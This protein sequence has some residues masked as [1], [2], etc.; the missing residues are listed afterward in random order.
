MPNS[1][2]ES[3]QIPIAGGIGEVGGLS[4]SDSALL[5]ET[6]PNSPFWKSD[7]SYTPSDLEKDF[8]S[9]VNT[10]KVEKGYLFPDGF[11]RDFDANEKPAV[12]VEMATFAVSPALGR[13]SAE[14]QSAYLTPKNASLNIRRSCA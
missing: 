11:N 7:E 5:K 3:N 10:G 14:S 4:T 8:D 1:T 13:S 9:L 2:V 6:F 12:P